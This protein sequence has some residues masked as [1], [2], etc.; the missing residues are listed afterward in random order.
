MC[1]HTHTHKYIH[2]NEASTTLLK[3]NDTNGL[4]GI[5]GNCIQCR[6]LKTQTVQCLRRLPGKQL[7][8][9][10]GIIHKCKSVCVKRITVCTEPDFNLTYVRFPDNQKGRSNCF[11]YIYF[12]HIALQLLFELSQ[13][14]KT[15]FTT[16][17]LSSLFLDVVFWI[18]P[19]GNTYPFSA[20]L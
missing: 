11:F 20:L 18:Y 5:I 6:C 9:L 17:V 10:C 19:S 4:Y 16:T 7:M 1:I 14:F 8:L 12:Y 2:G 13:L 3:Q 15:F